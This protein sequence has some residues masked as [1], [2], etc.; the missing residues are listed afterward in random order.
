LLNVIDD[1]TGHYLTD[2]K[3]NP[4]D[5]KVIEAKVYLDADNTFST[6]QPGNFGGEYSCQKS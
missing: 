6:V 5:R 4:Y 1:D 2:T 3:G